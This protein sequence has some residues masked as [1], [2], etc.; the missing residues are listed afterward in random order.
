MNAE[1]NEARKKLQALRRMCE[2]SGQP[3]YVEILDEVIPVL[4]RERDALTAPPSED[5]VERVADLL[6]QHIDLNGH[7]LDGVKRVARKI[8]AMALPQGDG[9]KRVCSVCTAVVSKYPE[10]MCCHCQEMP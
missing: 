1:S 8:A 7:T 3:F 4:A 10:G 6:W 9:P 5:V 2:A